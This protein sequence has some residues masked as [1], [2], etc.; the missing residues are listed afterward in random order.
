MRPNIVDVVAPARNAAS[1]H[2]VNRC[3]RAPYEANA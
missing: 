3:R 2:G 1:A